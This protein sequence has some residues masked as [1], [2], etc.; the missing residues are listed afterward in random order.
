MITVFKVRAASPAT[1]ETPHD[2]EITYTATAK[3]T[4]GLRVR[5][6]PA[7]TI[8]HAETGKSEVTLPA[9]DVQRTETVKVI[10]GPR[11]TSNIEVEIIAEGTNS[12]ERCFVHLA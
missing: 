2:L 1:L 3:E 12:R 8:K 11:G 5:P 7:M 9:S 10:L 4:V 6:S